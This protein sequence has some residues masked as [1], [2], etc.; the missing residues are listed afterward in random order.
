MAGELA[1]LT[2]PEVGRLAERGAVLAVPLG[3]TEQHGP[4]LTLSVDTD[5]A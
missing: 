5:V 1:D 4:H 3:S 2:S